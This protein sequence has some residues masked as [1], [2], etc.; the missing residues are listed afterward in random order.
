MVNTSTQFNDYINQRFANVTP[1]GFFLGDGNSQ[2]I[3]AYKGNGDIYNGVFGQNIMDVMLTNISIATQFQPFDILWAPGAG[4]SLQL[5]VYFG[6]A[7]A[8]YPGFFALY[9]TVE[10]VRNIRGLEYSNGVRSLPLWL[11]YM[12]FDF[13]IVLVSSALS[14]MIFAAASSLFYNIGYLFI[15]FA[16]FGLAS[17]LLSYVVSLFA[18]TQLSAYAFAA[19]GQAVMFLVYLIGYLCTLTYAPVNKIDDYLLIVHFTISPVTP[20]G[21]LIRALFVALNIFLRLAL[22]NTWQHTPLVFSSTGGQ[23]CIS[24]SKYLSCS[25][26][27][28]G[29]IVDPPP[30]GTDESEGIQRQHPRTT[31]LR[32][33]TI[34]AKNWLVCGAQMTDSGS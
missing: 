32:M 5:V 17:I 3:L 12:T 16:L 7:M 8:A 20:I 24:S 21:S 31:F 22:A 11:A 34:L 14:V 33:K 1:A 4:K 19:A 2:T 15:I 23:F 27:F 6:L 26:F 29:M 28:S 13:M 25:P 18:R 30:H 9:P 10:R